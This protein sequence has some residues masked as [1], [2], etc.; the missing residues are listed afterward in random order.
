MPSSW[1]VEGA[2]VK[3]IYTLPGRFGKSRLVRPF[4][5]RNGQANPSKLLC[6]ESTTAFDPS[7]TNSLSVT[8]V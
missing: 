1:S 2:L 6:N 3:V 8:M 7:A 5:T 4:V